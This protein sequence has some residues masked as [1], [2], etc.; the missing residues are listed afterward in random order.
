MFDRSFIEKIE[1]MAAPRVI[2]TPQGTFTNQD[3]RRIEEKMAVTLTLN[4]LSGLVAMIKHENKEYNT[5]L[6]VRI[7]SP[8][9]ID[10]FGK[11]RDDS[12]REQPFAARAVLP[13]FRFDS[14]IPVED[15]I[16]SLKARFAQTEDRDYLL[17]LLGNITDNQSVQTKDDGITQSATIRSGIQLV[18]EERIKPVVSLKPYRTFLEVEQPESDF[19]IRLKEGYAA[20]YEADGGAWQ[21]EAMANIGDLLREMLKDTDN[22]I[23]VE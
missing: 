11:I 4:T 1:T 13:Q 17:R 18:G 23:I 9:Q 22:V 3:F 12:Q 6:Y 10:V 21:N 20:L 8:T 19:L 15:M 5:P 7:T 16:I 2:E 14:Y